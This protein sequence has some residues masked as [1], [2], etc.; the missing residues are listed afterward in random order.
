MRALFATALFVMVALSGC[1]TDGG[2]A[3]VNSD[4]DETSDAGNQTVEPVLPMNNTAPLAQL[5][6]EGLEA[7][8]GTLN[9]T[10]PA[11][12]NFT[13]NGTDVDGDNLTWAFAV[14]GTET[15]NGTQLPAVVNHTFDLVGLF[16]V[17]FT[18]AD[19]SNATVDML[20]INAAMGE[21]GFM[22]TTVSFEDG[23]SD[24]NEFAEILGVQAD[25]D[26]ET[27]VIVMTLHEVWPSTQVLSA[28]TYSVNVNGN[29]FNSFVRYAIDSNPMT[30]DDAAGA[31]L[32]AGASVWTAETV[33]FNLPISLLEGNGVVAPFEVFATA[34]YGALN[35]R[36]VMDRAPD[37][38]AA[39]L[40]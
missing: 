39:L 16:N 24:G 4:V 32:G 18:V 30:W 5:G 26:G 19:A 36:E 27:L 31:Y 2:T 22:A 40:V 9:V 25:N 10:A 28:A 11:T 12:L 23:D 21:L 15:F 17:T 8:N 33:T 20:V 34:N 7:F 6:V 29:L 1:A 37:A 35:N 13:L 38:G 3:P 14:N